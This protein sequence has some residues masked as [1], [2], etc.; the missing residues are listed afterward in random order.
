MI[1]VLTNIMFFERK[2]EN[3]IIYDRNILQNRKI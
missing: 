2:G 3:L 1:K